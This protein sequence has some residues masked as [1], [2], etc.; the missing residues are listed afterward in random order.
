MRVVVGTLRHFNVRRGI[1]TRQSAEVAPGIQPAADTCS[2]R[3]IA[4]SAEVEREIQRT[5]CWSHQRQIERE[6]TSGPRDD[7]PRGTS[8]P[9]RL[10]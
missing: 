5:V 9:A 1:S 2:A 3:L 8:M 4:G 6:G 10:E 7:S